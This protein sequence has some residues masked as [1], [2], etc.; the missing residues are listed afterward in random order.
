MFTC[1]ECGHSEMVHH[2]FAGCCHVKDCPCLGMDGRGPTCDPEM[3]AF[4]HNAFVERPEP[5]TELEWICRRH[6]TDPDTVDTVTILRLHDE[7]LGAR[8]ICRQLGLNRNIV[9]AVI[10]GAR[11][12]GPAAAPRTRPRQ[13]DRERALA[14]GITPEEFQAERIEGGRAR[15]IADLDLWIAERAAV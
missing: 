10:H 6:G 11:G 15:T 13:E 4:A 5:K 7:G 14:A 12:K 9:R 3:H 2:M 1:K 8:T